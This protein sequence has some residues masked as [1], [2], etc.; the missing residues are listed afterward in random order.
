MI[1]RAARS[2]R[3]IPAACR[4]TGSAAGAQVHHDGVRLGEQPRDRACPMR[5][6]G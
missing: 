6:P 2:G 3:K 4:T 1:I 5:R